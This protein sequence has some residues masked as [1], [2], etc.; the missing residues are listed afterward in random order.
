MLVSKRLSAVAIA[1]SLLMLAACGRESGSDARDLETSIAG[2]GNG[3]GPG[4]TATAIINAD[5]TPGEWLS[6]GRTYSEQRFSPL[7]QV[8]RENVRELGLAW[9]FDFGVS[10]GIEATPIVSDGV[11]YVTSSWNIV[12]ALNAKTGDVVWQ[13]DPQVDKSRAAVMCCDIVNRGVAI[14]GNKV[15][16]GTIDGRLIAIDVKTGDAVWDVNTIDRSKPYSITGAPRV[17]KGKV[18]I[19]NG[20]AEFGVRGYISAYDANTGEMLWRFHTVPGNPDDGFENDAMKAAAATWTGEWWAAGGGGTVWDSMAY[21]AELDL[22]YIGVGNGSPWNQ[23]LRSPDGG[24]NLFLSSIVALRPDSGDYVWHYQTTPGDTWDFTATQHMI[25]AELEIGGTQRKVIMQAPKNGFFYVVDRETG[26]LLS[27]KNYVP[28]NWATHVDMETGRPVEVADAR[29]PGKAPYLQL[30]GP[31]GAHNWHPM[32]YSP[33]TG[34]VYIP[35]QEAPFAYGDDPEYLYKEGVW[36]TGANMALASLPTDEATL[37]AVKAMLKGRILAWDPV[38]QE[39]AWS[40]EHKGPWNGGLLSTAGGLVFQGTADAHFA[41]Y[42]ASTGGQLWSFFSQTGIVAAPVSY[43]IDGEQYVAVASGWGGSYALAYGGVAPTGSEA[44]VGRVLTFKLGAN[45][46]L[47][48]SSAIPAGIPKLPAQTATAGSI[49]RGFDAYTR[50]CISCHGDHAVSSGI[51]PDLRKSPYLLSQESWDAVV[52]Q[53]ALSDRGM[54]NFGEFLDT[55]T[56]ASIRAYVIEQA[57]MAV[58]NGDKAAK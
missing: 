27:A 36:N 49:A 10:R 30:P 12:S 48:G 25:L 8:S 53:G 16:T 14:W 11:M 7:S 6:H 46:A 45:E 15:Y 34:L 37:A 5:D 50:Y 17:V 1:V 52:R 18:I 51:L 23:E 33:I 4:I 19:G 24:D 40:F 38:K 56:A 35:A 20:G 39:A 31:L 57:R 44:G 47:P 22:L 9:A 29:W 54:G 42:D 21:D 2:A 43:E 41:A 13:Y 58:E 3:G 28:T 26:E 55:E 32:S